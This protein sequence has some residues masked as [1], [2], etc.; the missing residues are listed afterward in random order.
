MDFTIK[1]EFRD[2]IPPLADEEFTQLEQSILEEGVRDPLVVWGN[3]GSKPVLVDGHH[4]WTIIRRKPSIKYRV[5]I[6]KFKGRDEAKLW[7]INNQRGRRNLP[8]FALI[9]LE[10]LR[11]SILKLQAKENQ[12]QSA[13]RGKK[14]SRIREPLSTDEEI[15]KGSGVSK[16]TVYRTR[17]LRKNADSYTTERLR[18]GQISINEA[19]RRVK[20]QLGSGDGHQSASSKKARD[21]GAYEESVVTAHVG[22]NALLMKHV[23]RLYFKKGYRIADVTYGKG[24]FWREINLSAY[25]FHASDIHTCAEHDYDFRH[26]PYDNDSFNVVVL[27]PPYA[28]NPGDLIVDDSYSNSHTTKRMYHDDILE[29]YRQGMT[30]AK[31]ILKR[32]GLLLVKCQDEVESSKQRWSH[33]EILNIAVDEL[34]MADEDLFVLVR[35]SVPVVQHKRQQHARKNHSYLWVLRKK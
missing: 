6:R 11:E 13:G 4:R 27:D 32:G 35:S 31:R 34:G 17:F 30:E 18:K 29:L 19:Y 21:S 7:I 15:A 16:E 24:V 33:I 28:H 20:S 10:M 23:A 12:R 22:D 5:V 3:N 9:E 2:L 26:L 1:K 14:G 25:D 8:K